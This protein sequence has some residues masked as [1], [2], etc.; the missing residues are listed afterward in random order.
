[1]I[2]CLCEGVTDR[3]VRKLARQGASSLYE[4][5]LACSA[6]ASCGACRETLVQV[7]HSEKKIEQPSDRKL[8]T[9]S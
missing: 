2:I 6:G 5:A 4:V 1:M 8:A 3:T 7:L 9:A